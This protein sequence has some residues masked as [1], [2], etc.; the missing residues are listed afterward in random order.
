LLLVRDGRDAQF[1]AAL[2]KHTGQTLWKTDRPPINVSSPNLKKSFSSPLIVEEAGRTQVIVPGAHWAVAYEPST[3]QELWR[4]RHGD[5]FSIGTSPVYG[6]S[7]VFFGTGCFRPQLW[8]VRVDGQG[9]VTTTHATWK[10]TRQVPVMSSPVLAGEELYWVSDDGMVTCA[11][12]RN[13][14]VY[15]QERVGGACLASP[16]SASGRLYFFRQDATTV[17]MRAGRRFE[18]LAENPLEG[19]LIAS[20]ALDHRTLYLRTDT[21]LYALRASPALE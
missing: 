9:D 16:V 4:L 17:V 21:H 5:G 13:G 19:T 20:P 3:G 11:D 1:V 6:Q 8:A 18:R 14:Q 10:T 12:A 7:N 15:W 2:D